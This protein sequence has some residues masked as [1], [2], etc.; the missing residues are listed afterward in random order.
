[1]EDNFKKMEDN[2]KQMDRNNRVINLCLGIPIT[3][4]GNVPLT[5]ENKKNYSGSFGKVLREMVADNIRLAD[6]TTCFNALF[7]SMWGTSKPDQQ[8]SEQD[9]KKYIDKMIKGEKIT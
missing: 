8:L 1:M 5:E 2:F 3:Y 4:E 7:N 9:I 6:I